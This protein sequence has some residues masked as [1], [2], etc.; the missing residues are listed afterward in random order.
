MTQTHQAQE[1]SKIS[2]SIP[3]A[4][5][6]ETNN[7]NNENSQDNQNSVVYNLTQQD[8]EFIFEAAGEE[9]I[10]Q[11]I[12]SSRTSSKFS[13]TRNGSLIEQTTTVTKAV[14]TTSKAVMAQSETNR[15]V[16]TSRKQPRCKKANQI[17]LSHFNLDSL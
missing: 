7:N 17:L 12:V 5:P 11:R 2:D 6:I 16:I 4:S 10:E 9:Q 3:N 1:S 13:S 14:A 15:Q 8:L